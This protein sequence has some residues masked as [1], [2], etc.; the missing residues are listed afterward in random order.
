MAIGLQTHHILSKSKNNSSLQK[1]HLGRSSPEALRPPS[2]IYCIA[3]RIQVATFA[4]KQRTFWWR[5]S[6]GGNRPPN[7]PYNKSKLKHFYVLKPAKAAFMQVQ[8]QSAE[9]STI[10]IL[11]CKQCSGSH[12]CSKAEKFLV[13]VF[14]QWQ[15]AS[16]LTT[17]LSSQAYQSC[18]Y[19]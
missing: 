13:E 10:D 19:I 1:L 15:W 11:H 17:L 18:I 14:Y 8:F 3:N 12:L 6:I 2:L 7:S 5:F 16:K 9:T 4:A